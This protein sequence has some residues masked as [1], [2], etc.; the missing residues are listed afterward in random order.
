MQIETTCHLVRV[1][2]LTAPPQAQATS[3]LHPFWKVGT[4]YSASCI[5]CL[6][7]TFTMSLGILQ[8]SQ[9]MVIVLCQGQS[10]LLAPHAAVPPVQ[11]RVL[12]HRH[13]AGVA[14]AAFSVDIS[15]ARYDLSQVML[16][17]LHSDRL[18]A[19][20]TGPLKVLTAAWRLSGSYG[21]TQLDC[22]TQ[23]WQQGDFLNN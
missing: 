15:A 2:R 7:Q 9:S 22:R 8:I 19:V 6:K 16:R 21:G 5:L 14:R 4:R 20:W 18:R 1:L 10:G 13:G 12:H 23:E 11:R 3:T 17:R